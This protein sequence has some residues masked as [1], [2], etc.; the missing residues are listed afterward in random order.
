[1]GSTEKLNKTALTILQ[2]AEAVLYL[3]AA[4]VWEIAIKAAIGKLALPEKP[5]NFVANATRALRL[6]ALPITPLHALAVFELPAYHGDPF[7]RMLI[8]QA[9][10]ENLTLL[11][12]D[13]VFQK[14]NLQVIQCD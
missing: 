14:Y 13:R 3:S 6:V 1:M 12:V 2:D 7:D 8:A 5:D 11:T 10:V 9:L 4:S